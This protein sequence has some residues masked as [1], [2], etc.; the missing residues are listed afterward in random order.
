M[1]AAGYPG[2]PRAGDRIE[3]LD[4]PL[5]AG[6]FVRHA[7]TRRDPS[8]AFV[9]AGGRVLT[10]GGHGADLPTAARAAYEAVAQIR[11]HGE[12]HRTDIGARAGIPPSAS[13]QGEP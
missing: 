9:T 13:R 8:G 2:T 5:P 7:G 10:V 12:H 11:W 4:A 3:G 1:A 6:A